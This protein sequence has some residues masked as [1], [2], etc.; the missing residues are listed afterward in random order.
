[1]V[2][3]LTVCLICFGLSACAQLS[4][5]SAAARGRVLARVTQSWA[6]ALLWLLGLEI[7]R[8]GNL[9]PGHSL[10]VANHQSYLDIIILAAH[11]PAQFVAKHEVSRWPLLGWLAA[12][13]G[14]IFV[15]RESTLSSVQCVYR[16]SR[17]LRAGLSVLA[18]PEGTTSDGTRV[19]PFK[20]LL[21]A[22][23]VRT[24]T[25]V[26]PLT[27][28]FT[29]VNG[30]PLDDDTRDLLCWHG[31]MGFAQHFWRLLACRATTARLTV[32]TPLIVSRKDLAHTLTP[33]VHSLI[34]DSF[35]TPAFHERTLTWHVTTKTNAPIAQKI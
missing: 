25:P 22:A 10:L 8:K 27:I 7:E 33:I 29:S 35:A 2:G 23:A 1:L 19:L 32:H 34:A 6:R 4:C 18:F 28:N 11:F 13:G 20:P 15:E 9:P 26:L 14:T 17:A 5:R 12:L 31:E 3:F 16:V 21:L 24:Q 30:A